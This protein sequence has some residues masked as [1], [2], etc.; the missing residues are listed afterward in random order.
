MYWSGII[1]AISGITSGASV[2]PCARTPPVAAIPEKTKRLATR[3]AAMNLLNNLV[4]FPPL[5]GYSDKLALCAVFN[6][7]I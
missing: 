5:L 4:I 2:D 7:C 1:S 3:I 6:I